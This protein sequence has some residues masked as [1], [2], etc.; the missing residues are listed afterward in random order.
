[1]LGTAYEISFVKCRKF[2]SQIWVILTWSA[3]RNE[4]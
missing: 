3:S 1:M 2:G 4:R